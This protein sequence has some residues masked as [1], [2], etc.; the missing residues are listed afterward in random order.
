MPRKDRKKADVKAAR[1][2][3][4]LGLYICDSVSWEGRMRSWRRKDGF[5]DPALFHVQWWELGLYEGEKG[6][7]Y[8]LFPFMGW[9]KL[10]R[11]S[12]I[13]EDAAARGKGCRI[14]PERKIEK[15]MY[16]ILKR[17]SLLR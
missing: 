13:Q 11:G 10:H 2:A 7:A 9:E 4:A 1:R 12:L 15:R 16:G 6:N 5:S 3:L 17:C 14:A 8:R